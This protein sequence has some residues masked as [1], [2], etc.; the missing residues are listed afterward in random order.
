MSGNG[1]AIVVVK[2]GIPN[3]GV[4]PLD[5]NACLL[6]KSPSASVVIENPYISRKHAQITKG[7]E[8]FEIQDLGSKNGTFVNGARVEEGVC[9]KLRNGDQIELAR[10]QVVLMFQEWGVTSTLP[11]PEQSAPDEL[12]VNV[13]SREVWVLG[14]VLGPPL[15]RKEF[16][17]LSLLYQRRGEALSK[18]EI[19]IAGWPERVDGDVADQDIEQCIRRLRLRV[20]PVPSRPTLIL[21]VR[22][23]GYKLTPP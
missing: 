6:G 22:G 4:I 18:D 19:A 17:V 12:V 5:Q 8:T 3:V 23:Y 2:R 9:K 10:G 14:T 16:D 7:S 21:T 15:S 11:P 13:R 1:D 20:E